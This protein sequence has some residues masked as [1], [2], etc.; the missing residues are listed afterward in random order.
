T[1]IGF[2]GR[3][4]LLKHA[5]DFSGL[6]DGSYFTNLMLFVKAKVGFE[7]FS[8]TILVCII[9]FSSACA[10]YRAFKRST[11][12][13]L[14]ALPTFLFV[15]ILFGLTSPKGAFTPVTTPFWIAGLA[16]FGTLALFR[17]LAAGR[18][19]RSPAA[20]SAYAMALCGLAMLAFY[21]FQVGV[22]RRWGTSTA[23]AYYY[24][25]FPLA[26]C[27][28]AGAGIM[29]IRAASAAPVRPDGAS[30][31]SIDGTTR[32]PRT[33][34]SYAVTA[35]LAVVF[36]YSVHM[37]FPTQAYVQGVMAQKD[38]MRDIGLAACSEAG[39]AAPGERLFMRARLPFSR[40]PDCEALLQGH[41]DFVSSMSE[42]STTTGGGFQM[43]ANISAGHQCPEVAGRLASNLTQ[44]NKSTDG[45]SEESR[46]FYE[47]YFK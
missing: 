15:M 43:L 9:L 45:D 24:V 40:C 44:A 29:A 21:I 31:T 32:L 10:L 22:G 23:L 18:P 46:R 8:T 27:W 41:E 4:R 17:R 30:A 42:G 37:Y 3:S 34:F 25:M 19:Q 1:S 14:P 33:A 39:R 5:P 11:P 12:H 16:L 26:G 13:R 2:A 38:F 7:K 47:K 6:I 35:A 20:T 28:Q 36:A